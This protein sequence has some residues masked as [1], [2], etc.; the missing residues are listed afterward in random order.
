MNLQWALSVATHRI[1]WFTADQIEKYFWSRVLNHIKSSEIKDFW[2]VMSTIRQH[3]ELTILLLHLFLRMESMKGDTLQYKSTQTTLTW[4][5]IYF[6]SNHHQPLLEEY[7]TNLNKSL[8][9]MTN[10]ILKMAPIS[11]QKIGASNLNTL[12]MSKSWLVIILK[13]II[14]IVQF[15]KCE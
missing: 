2:L 3:W 4:S 5:Q 7:L 10:L 1:R 6:F 8:E 15:V 14:Q 12:T 11:L 9:S 13:W